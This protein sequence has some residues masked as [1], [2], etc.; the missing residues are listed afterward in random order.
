MFLFLEIESFRNLVSI[1]GRIS[2]WN[3]WISADSSVQQQIW[4]CCSSYYW[5]YVIP[6]SWLADKQI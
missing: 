4:K 6:A 5:D 3:E 2:V 1:L